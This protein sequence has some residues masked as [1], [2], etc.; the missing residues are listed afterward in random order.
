ME[1]ARAY[2][3]IQIAISELKMLFEQNAESEFKNLF[4]Q[5]EKMAKSCGRTTEIKIRCGQ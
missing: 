4:Q 2:E 1:V 5:T 3:A